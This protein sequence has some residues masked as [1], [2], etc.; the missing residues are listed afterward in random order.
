MRWT[1]W[2]LISLLIAGPAQAAIFG[3]DLDKQDVPATNL[4]ENGGF[5]NGKARWTSSGSAVFS[6]VTSGANLAV[7]STTASWDAT[8]DTEA[9]ASAQVAITQGHENK[10]CLASWI[11]KGGDTN[12]KAQVIDGTSAVLASVDLSATTAF[13]PLQMPYTCP[14]SGTVAFRLLAGADAAIV[15]LDSVM[16]GSREAPV[17]INPVV[18]KEDRSIGTVG[19]VA[20][21]QGAISATDFP[22]PASTARWSFSGD[23]V[24]A[25]GLA[26]LSANIQGT[27]TGGTAIFNRKGILASENQPDV[28]GH[29]FRLNGDA[30]TDPD[31]G[32]FTA[33]LWVCKADWQVS[34]AEYF[35]TQGAGTSNRVFGLVIDSDT[36]ISFDMSTN[37][38][39]SFDVQLEVVQSFEANSCHHFVIAHD[40]TNNLLLA[41]I[42]GQ[43]VGTAAIASLFNPAGGSERFMIGADNLGG[44]GLKGTVQDAFLAKG[45]VLTAAQVNAIYSR[46]FSNH[47]QIAGGHTLTAG[48]FPFNELTDKVYFWN[49]SD[50]ANDDSGNAENLTANG[51][52]T[53]GSGAGLFGDNSATSFDG[54]DDNFSLAS[55]SLNPDPNA[56]SF[57]YG[58]WA[59]KDD[60]SSTSSQMLVSN[61]PSS[62]DR[63]FNIFVGAGTISGR[64]ATTATTEGGSNY[65]HNFTDGSWHHV[66]SR[67]DSGKKTL[68]LFLDGVKVQ[69]DTLA[70]AYQAT[71]NIFRVGA[72]ASTAEL[73]WEGQLD[74]PFLV[75]EYL[76]DEDIRK[77]A[78]ARIDR[79][80]TIAVENQDWSASLWGREDGKINNQLDPSWLLDTS[81]TSLYLDTG[82]PEGSSIRLKLKDTGFNAN[83]IATATYNSGE[84][85]SAPTFPV[86]HGLPGRPQHVVVMTEGQ[87]VAGKWDSRYDLCS[88]DATEL[89]CDL[90]VLTIDGTHRVQ[91]IASMTPAGTAVKEVSQG[92]SGLVKSAGQLLGTNTNDTAPAGYVGE[93]IIETGGGGSPGATTVYV[94]LESITLTPGDWDVWGSA[95]LATG[96]S[97]ITRITAAINATSASST[98]S[99]NNGGL[100]TYSQPSGALDFATWLNVGPVRV[101]IPSTTTYYLNGAV[102]FSGSS[103]NWSALTSL[104]ARRVR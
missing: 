67:W 14:S 40:D 27:T 17:M 18:Y 77:L 26:T 25:A 95:V 88:A 57:T 43:P 9:L 6:T 70:T 35:M 60:W 99:T 82:L 23:S 51:G 50:D 55:A 12:L 97:G 5:E 81:A 4:L 61:F 59:Q 71:V 34:S 42:D 98:G 46:R 91:I 76:T 104:Q 78:S 22:T 83:V 45:D 32:D 20:N 37:G 53:A 1:N 58:V 79:P 41:Y 72:R 65:T 62:T 68:D 47:Q 44:L 89:D 80:T 36:Y 24:D 63:G 19:A 73:F 13:T 56:T 38:T 90:S 49:L 33:G 66:V 93:H 8:A 96:G 74:E 69:S 86:A 75:T 48:S 52:V 3:S 21:D 10:V 102:T 2:L 31:G 101:S 87:S 54:I 7:G 16:L 84:L 94:E 103:P 92:E 39:S 15:Y 30:D 11:W 100:A 28:T 64:L 29:Y 85:S